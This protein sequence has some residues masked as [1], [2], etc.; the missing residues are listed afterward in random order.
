[1]K[2]PRFHENDFSVFWHCVYKYTNLA[3]IKYT[4][5]ASP[6]TLV[7]SLYYQT[8]TLRD[9]KYAWFFLKF[10]AQIDQL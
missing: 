8:N 10:N 5:L 1:M 7:I 9:Q 3:S 2:S 4:E 6:T